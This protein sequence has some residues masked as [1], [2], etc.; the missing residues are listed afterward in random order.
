M[1][2]SFVVVTSPGDHAPDGVGAKP[3]RREK[4][5]LF[6]PAGGIRSGFAELAAPDIAGALE[7]GGLQTL[8]RVVNRFRIEPLVL[9]FAADPGGAEAARA[10]AAELRKSAGE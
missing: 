1:L 9:Q 5:H 10:K 4:A 3:P 7:L 6:C 2:D 8:D